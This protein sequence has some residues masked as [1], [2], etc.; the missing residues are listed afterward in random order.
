MQ[1]SPPKKVLTKLSRGPCLVPGPKYSFW[2]TWSGAKVS[3][4][5]HRNQLTAKPWENPVQ[6]LGNRGPM[7]CGLGLACIDTWPAV[8]RV[9]SRGGERLFTVLNLGNEVVLDQRLAFTT[10]DDILIAHAPCLSAR[11]C[12]AMY[13]VRESRSTF[14]LFYRLF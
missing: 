12:D 9:L 13:R 11:S 4:I 14:E 5:S 6:E 1:H 3:G 7:I 2:V 10:L 8:T